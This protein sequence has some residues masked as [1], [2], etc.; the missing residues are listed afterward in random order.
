VN[1]ALAHALGARFGIPHG[2][3]NALFLPHVLRYNASLP[4]KF[5]PA[6]GYSAYVA[7]EKYAQLGRIL[8]GGHSQEE[9]MERLFTKVDELIVVIEVGSGRRVDGR[10]PLNVPRDDARNRGYPVGVGRTAIIR[11][12]QQ[13]DD[14]T[15]RAVAVVFSRPYGREFGYV[16]EPEDDP[17]DPLALSLFDDH[18]DDRGRGRGFYAQD[19]QE[20]AS[21][22][23]DLR[24]PLDLDVEP[25]EMEEGAPEVRA[26]VLGFTSSSRR[27]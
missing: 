22:R 14:A 24:G 19:E 26:I 13:L 2:R 18:D 21:R 15:L 4:T 3:A 17:D 7:P 12:G 8:F 25:I 20:R 5:M 27:A 6:P 23:V 1:H 9:Q 11:L 16:D 10:H